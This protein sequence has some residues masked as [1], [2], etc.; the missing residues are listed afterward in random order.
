MKAAET[1]GFC[2]FSVFVLAW[3]AKGRIWL[4]SAILPQLPGISFCSVAHGWRMRRLSV[5]VSA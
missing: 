1:L 5:T 2:G 3:E 4:V